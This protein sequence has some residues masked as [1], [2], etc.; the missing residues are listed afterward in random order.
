MCMI[1]VLAC[2]AACVSTGASHG[3]ALWIVNTV[4]Q[5]ELLSQS[6]PPSPPDGLPAFTVAFTTIILR[7]HAGVVSAGGC[8]SVQEGNA[9]PAARAS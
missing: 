9:E 8:V 2:L 5:W 7:A 6:P 1:P 3:G 4:L